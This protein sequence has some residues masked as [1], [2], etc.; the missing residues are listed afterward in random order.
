[1]IS[2]KVKNFGT[3]RTWLGPLITVQLKDDAVVNDLLNE[4]FRKYGGHV[5]D[6]LI[7]PKTGTVFNYIKI[8]KNGRIVFFDQGVNTPLADGDEIVII[9]YPSPLSL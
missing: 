3:L 7:D 8:I 2:V 6:L 9:P 1:M 4:L 5:K